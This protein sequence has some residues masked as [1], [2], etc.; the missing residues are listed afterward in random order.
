M[1]MMAAMATLTAAILG[2]H[3]H[4]GS[5]NSADDK[6]HDHGG[7]VDRCGRCYAVH[8]EA[9]GDAATTTT[10]TGEGRGGEEKGAHQRC[11]GPECASI[12]ANKKHRWC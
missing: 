2:R 11:I 4:G 6:E 9:F 1:M 10:T 5:G 7:H 8:A 12:M 3:N